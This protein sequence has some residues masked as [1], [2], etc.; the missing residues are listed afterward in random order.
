[1]ISKRP[2]NDILLRSQDPLWRG[3]CQYILLRNLMLKKRSFDSKF[4]YFY[5]FLRPYQNTKRN[6]PFSDGRH[7]EGLDFC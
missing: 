3:L 5:T 6:F 4:P 7:F 1:M 2:Y